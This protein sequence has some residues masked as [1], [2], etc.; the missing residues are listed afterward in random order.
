MTA[1]HS[2]RT[3]PFHRAAHIIAA[4]LVACTGTLPGLAHAEEGGSGHYLPGSMASFIDVVPPTEAFLARLNLVHYEG[5][6]RRSVLGGLA[7][8]NVDAKSMAYGLTVL[9]RPPIELAPG[10]SYAMSAT[11]PYLTMDVSASVSGGPIGVRR[12]DSV[13]GLGDILLMPLMINRVIDPDLSMNF[14]VA[15]YAPTGS[16]EVGRLANPGKNYWSIEPTLAVAYLGKQNGIEASLFTG[17]TF[18]QENKDTQYKSGTQF[19]LDGTLAQHFPF[20]GGLAGAGLSAYYYQQLG[21]DSGAGATLGDFKGKTL[22]IGPVLSHAG[23]LGGNDYVAEF[24]W[25]HESSTEN[26]LKGDI[27]WFKFLYKFY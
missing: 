2:G 22:G 5:S 18:N 7:V 27:V 16:Y 1:N 26:R 13:S 14:R 17:I 4:A 23:K 8:A 15:A 20:A 24:K 9:W 3:G 10:W 11:I 6:A 21:A 19:H 12:S 25:L